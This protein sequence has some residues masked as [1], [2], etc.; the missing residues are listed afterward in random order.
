M[1]RQGWRRDRARKS[2]P[3]C[4]ALR[5]LGA[6]A[7]RLFARHPDQGDALRAP[8]LARA[9]RFE[10]GKAEFIVNNTL[11]GLGRLPCRI[12]T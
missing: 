2:S 10:I 6:A 1:L 4:D 7:G 9:R 8:H 5:V 11:D 3:L 12:V